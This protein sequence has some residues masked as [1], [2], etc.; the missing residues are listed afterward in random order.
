MNR[1]KL[2]A[3]PD[4]TLCLALFELDLKKKKKQCDSKQGQESH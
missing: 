1:N 3:V 4:F 2:N